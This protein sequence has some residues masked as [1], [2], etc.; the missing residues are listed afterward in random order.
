T[1]ASLYLCRFSKFT[2]IPVR[3]LVG[4]PSPRTRRKGGAGGPSPSPRAG[5]DLGRGKQARAKCAKIE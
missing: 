3:P 5:R 1:A 4:P 2:P